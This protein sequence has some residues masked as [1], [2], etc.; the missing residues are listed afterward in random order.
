VPDGTPA[1]YKMMDQ[2]QLAASTG[3]IAE[4][5]FKLLSDV[6]VTGDAAR[7][8]APTLVLHGT[9]ETGVPFAEAQYITARIPNARL[10]PLATKNHLLLADESAWPHFLQA[11]DTFIG[12]ADRE[13]FKQGRP[14]PG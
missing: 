2:A 10:V 9:G 11:L 7:V 3:A 12:A 4:R 6:D 8:T 13:S 1:Q 14:S 5:F